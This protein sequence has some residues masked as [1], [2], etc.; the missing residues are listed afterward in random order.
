MDAEQVAREID[1]F[2]KTLADFVRGQA[3]EIKHLRHILT[4]ER[5]AQVLAQNRVHKAIAALRILNNIWS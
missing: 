4:V 5:E 1:R 3:A 2:D